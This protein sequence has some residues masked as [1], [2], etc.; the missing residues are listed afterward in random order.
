MKSSVTVIGLGAFGSTVALK[1]ARLGYDV[2]GIDLNPS[3]T[4]AIADRIAQAIVADSRDERVLRE[5][6]C[7]NLTSWW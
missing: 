5:L 2:L 6:G 4:N 3:R 7:M 1:L